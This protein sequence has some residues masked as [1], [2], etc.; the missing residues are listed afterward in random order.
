MLKQSVINKAAQPELQG[1][2][3]CDYCRLLD[4]VPTTD[5]SMRGSTSPS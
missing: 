1:H 4:M 2:V 3:R 5:R